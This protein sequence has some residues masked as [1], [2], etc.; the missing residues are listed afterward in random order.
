MAAMHATVK[1]AVTSQPAATGRGPC[2]LF[3]PHSP[4]RIVSMCD[5]VTPA[6]VMRSEPGCSLRARTSHAPPRPPWADNAGNLAGGEIAEH[7][8][9][10]TDTQPIS[11]R[12][13]PQDSLCCALGQ[14]ATCH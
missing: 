3:I 4:L 9:P 10:L 13:G 2:L 8:G 7:T 5:E 12:L 11:T 6:A 1:A 14:T